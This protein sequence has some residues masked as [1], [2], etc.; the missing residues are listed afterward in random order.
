MGKKSK[1]KLILLDFIKIIGFIISILL[2]RQ[3]IFIPLGALST[4]YWS[5]YD[6]RG[7]N[8]PWYLSSSMAIFLV[9]ILVCFIFVKF[10]DKRDWSYLRLK[11][12]NKLKLFLL[13]I[14]V[15]LALTLFFACGLILSGSVVFTVEPKS[16]GH[17]LFYLTLVL[18]GGLALVLNEELVA[19]GYVLKT[20]EN[21]SGAIFAVILSSL[22]F[23]L[24]HM[25]NPNT[26]LL[27][28]LNIF[29][30][31]CFLALVCIH[32]NN[33]WAPIGLHFG[34]NF[35]LYLF[36]LPLSGHQYPNPIFTLKY[37]EYSLLSGSRFGPEDSIIL[38]IL[39]SIIVAYIFI[40]LSRKA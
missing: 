32:Y 38:T 22:L 24:F 30:M 21:H 16:L 31:G 4:K 17:I 28:F 8:E 19:R 3:L 27:G 35:S 18:I 36:N 1:V 23:S 9:T 7:L 2:L 34:W 13:G 15:S 11:S 26:S 29:L 20:L 37:N 14:L 12:D 6:G 33:L 5:K 10:V 39:L 25:F 40:K